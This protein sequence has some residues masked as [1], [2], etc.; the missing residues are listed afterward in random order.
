VPKDLEDTETNFIRLTWYSNLLLQVPLSV[1]AA[2]PLCV[3]GHPE[4]PPVRG[5]EEGRTEEEEADSRQEQQHHEE[6]H[7]DLL[8]G[9]V[10]G[11]VRAGR[12]QWLILSWRRRSVF[13]LSV[14]TRDKKQ[15][16]ANSTTM[17]LIVVIGVF[18]A[19]EIPLSVLI[20]LHIISSRLAK[21]N[22]DKFNC[23]PV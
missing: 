4:H 10:Q 2:L 11:Q 12:L 6:V 23:L 21:Y 5:P 1:R 7:G 13:G 3:P 8:Q 15:R 16:D 22:R 18:L 17:M 14:E 19:V 9:Q 20:S